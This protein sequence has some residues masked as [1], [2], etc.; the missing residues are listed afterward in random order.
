M[1]ALISPGI[2]SWEHTLNTLRYADRVKELAV[3]DGEG[4][5]PSDGDV[6]LSGGEDDNVS[7]DD[8]RDSPLFP[9]VDEVVVKKRYNEDYLK[10]V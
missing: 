3:L 7:G 2:T 8:S 4:S 9:K 1:I 5:C 10:E 6:S